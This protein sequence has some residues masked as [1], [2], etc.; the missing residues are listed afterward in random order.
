[1][2]DVY[3]QFPTTLDFV[4]LN[5]PDS[6]GKY[7]VTLLLDPKTPDGQANIKII[8]EAVEQG[9][10][11]GIAKQMVGFAGRKPSDKDYAQ[12]VSMH[13]P[14]KNADMDRFTK[15]K[16]M[17]KTRSEVYPEMAGKYV[18]TASTKRDLR[19]ERCVI[20]VNTREVPQSNQ[21]Y[22]GM[23]GLVSLWVAPY[24]N[25]DGLGLSVLLNSVVRT[26][27]GERLGGTP[28]PFAGFNLPPLPVQTPA[29]AV[30]NAFDAMGVPT[31]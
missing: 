31:V 18:L 25:K 6:H 4:H 14:L 16:N 22:S 5:K 10:A 1:M 7:S 28:D 8:S 26:G 27:D 15:G 24:S 19:G 11:E 13:N 21:L 20:D 23:L 29:P 12:F 3:T 30:P 17:G 9:I 2:A